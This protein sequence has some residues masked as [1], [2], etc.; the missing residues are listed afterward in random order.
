MFRLLSLAFG[1]LG[2]LEIA[3]A[4]FMYFAIMA[5]SGFWPQRLL[6]LRDIWSMRGINDI[7]DAYGQEWVSH[8]HI[9]LIITNE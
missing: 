9:I 6:G 5:E 7:E 1:Q 2:L 3:G 4:F 8:L